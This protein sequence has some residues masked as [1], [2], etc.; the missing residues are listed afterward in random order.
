MSAIEEFL[1]Q[2]KLMRCESL[3]ANITH[4]H[5]KSNKRSGRIFACRDCAGLTELKETTEMGSGKGKCKQCGREGLTLPGGGLCGK[6]YK[7]AR[8]QA[9]RPIP[10]KSDSTKPKPAKLP[11]KP[12]VTDEERKAAP[13]PAAAYEHEL[14][15]VSQGETRECDELSYL[16]GL[17]DTKLNELMHHMNSQPTP[18]ERAR[19]YLDICTSIEF[20][21]C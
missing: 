17:M 21:G 1:S 5:C 13:L 12:M 20:L 6:C 2:Q 15:P 7:A 3:S 4:D 16:R 9:G 8:D 11:G 10:G 19:Y 18:R 14:P